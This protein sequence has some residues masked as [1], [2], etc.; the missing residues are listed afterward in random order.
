MDMVLIDVEI[1]SMSDQVKCILLEIKE[2]FS[3]FHNE[4]WHWGEVSVSTVRRQA[5]L[6]L[7]EPMPEISQDI[8][9]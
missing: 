2:L 9:Q 4:Q 3:L 7:W 1:V 6:V 5:K 8:F